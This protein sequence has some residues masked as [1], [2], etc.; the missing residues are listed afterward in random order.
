MARVGIKLVGDIYVMNLVKLEEH[1]GNNAQ[2][3]Y[4]LSR[5]IDHNPVVP[6][7]VRAL[8]R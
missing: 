2:R 3:L 6:N 8:L 4:E 1:F 7:R 5:G